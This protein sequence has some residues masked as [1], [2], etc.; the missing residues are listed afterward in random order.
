[1]IQKNFDPSDFLHF[2]KNAV[3]QSEE[4]K[5]SE[6]FLQCHYS[7]IQECPEDVSWSASWK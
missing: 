7:P 3:P 6:S 1:M 2:F 4:C 5:S